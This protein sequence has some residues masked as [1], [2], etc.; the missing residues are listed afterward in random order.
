MVVPGGRT[1]LRG[2][3]HTVAR[4]RRLA[5]E[6]GAHNA[7]DATVAAKAFEGLRLDLWLDFPDLIPSPMGK[8]VE[9]LCS[10][11]GKVSHDLLERLYEEGVEGQLPTLNRASSGTWRRRRGRIALFTARPGPH[12]YQGIGYF[13]ALCA[14]EDRTER[15]SERRSPV[16]PRKPLV[17]IPPSVSVQEQQIALGY[18]RLPARGFRDRNV[19]RPRSSRI[20]VV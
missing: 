12:L 8:G 10:S 3:K 1:R 4:L 7:K 16:D 2:S 19:A 14:G 11:L 18:S 5:M 15:P 6:K 20:R 9:Q 17:W 13:Q